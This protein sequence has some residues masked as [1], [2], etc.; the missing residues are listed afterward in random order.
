MGIKTD[1]L[2]PLRWDDGSEGKSKDA[3]ERLNDFARAEFLGALKVIAQNRDTF[4]ARLLGLFEFRQKVVRKK[5]RRN[6]EWGF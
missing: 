5:K 4:R 2:P 3:F 1:E 6:A